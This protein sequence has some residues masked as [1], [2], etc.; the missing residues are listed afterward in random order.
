MAATG[1][2]ER[3]VAM[4]RSF[5]QQMLD[6]VLARSAKEV[7]EIE[8][9]LLALSK[10]QLCDLVIELVR[11]TVVEE[12]RMRKNQLDVFRF[13]K[14]SGGPRS[15]SADEALMLVFTREIESAISDIDEESAASEKPHLRDE[16]GA[17]HS[18]IAEKRSEVHAMQPS[19]IKIKLL[20]I[21]L[22]SLDSF[23]PECKNYGEDGGALANEIDE[24]LL[25]C[26]DRGVLDVN[27]PV[28]RKVV[29]TLIDNVQECL[30]R[31]QELH[32]SYGYFRDLAMHSDRVASRLLGKQPRKAED[33]T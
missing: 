2:S 17:L 12:G 26:L 29:E 28:T 30:E 32:D 13:L 27:D 31:F 14:A 33:L 7:L 20:L 9:G 8:K 18:M 11:P 3:A 23:D 4:S 24:D 10:E 25:S 6:N 5:E 22:G 21:L 15:A 19:L 1:S 16:A